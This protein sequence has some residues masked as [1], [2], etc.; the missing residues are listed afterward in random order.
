MTQEYNP[1]L[2][3]L[4]FLSN[5]VKPLL[6]KTVT[7]GTFSEEDKENITDLVTEFI[8]DTPSDSPAVLFVSGLHT[9]ALDGIRNH[10][11]G[12]FE[13]MNTVSA[14]TGK[15]GF[16]AY[17]HKYKT[18]NVEDPA[19]PKAASNYFSVSLDKNVKN[20]V[21]FYS[22]KKDVSSQKRFLAGAAY[23]HS[24]GTDVAIIC[25]DETANISTIMNK[26]SRVIVFGRNADIHNSYVDSILRTLNK[27]RTTKEVAYTPT[28]VYLYG[29]D[30]MEYT[31]REMMIA[32]K[33][34]PFLEVSL[35]HLYNN[36]NSFT[37]IRKHKL[38]SIRTIDHE[39]VITRL[40]DNHHKYVGNGTF[41]DKDIRQLLIVPSVAKTDIS[42]VSRMIAINTTMAQSGV[43]LNNITENDLKTNS[44]IV[45]ENIKDVLEFSIGDIYLCK[46]ALQVQP[47][48][49][50]RR[51][52]LLDAL[53]RAS[54]DFFI[55]EDFL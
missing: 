7:V 1:S 19:N 36:R 32:K 13:D 49:D 11:V 39:E 3:D 50:G 6:A 18:A 26:Y 41:A 35:A 21:T 29:I 27:N 54:G 42:S 30:A 43:Y 34:T 48:E 20:N 12:M 24:Y 45:A 8:F 33:D 14:I 17:S 16:I 23:V 47:Y 44:V 25:E 2:P 52:I 9:D 31:C 51:Q 37:K 46:S 15:E 38:L 22:I 40:I 28:G 5:E 4:Q 53:T 55:I 10:I